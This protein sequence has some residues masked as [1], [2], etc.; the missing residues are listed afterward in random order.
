ML[1]KTRIG[2]ICALIWLCN[3]PQH[4]A[5]HL[6]ERQLRKPPTTCQEH[7]VRSIQFSLSIIIEKLEHQVLLMRWRKYLRARPQKKHVQEMRW[8]EHRRAQPPKMQMQAMRWLEHLRAQPHQN[9]FQQR[10]GAS[11][12]VSRAS[13]SAAP[14]SM[15]TPPQM[16]QK[17]G[18]GAS[19]L[20]EGDASTI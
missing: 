10:G 15:L 2:L 19:T 9:I 11:I 8:L 18:R 14:A 13:R 4:D 7:H 16:P 17:R 6:C 5:K 20:P 1:Q 12:S 3:N